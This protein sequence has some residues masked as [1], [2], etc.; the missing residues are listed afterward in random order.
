MHTSLQIIQIIT[1]EIHENIDCAVFHI[2]KESAKKNLGSCPL[3][4]TDKGIYYGTRLILHPGFMEKM[5]KSFCVIL[6]TNKPTNHIIIGRVSGKFHCAHKHS[7]SDWA[8]QKELYT[9]CVKLD[10]LTNYDKNHLKKTANL[11]LIFN[12]SNKGKCSAYQAVF[13]LY[14][15]LAE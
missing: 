15:N 4:R 6:L 12:P 10:L 2:I 14:A 1:W 9:F 8:N 3:S 5:S 13:S 7:G 11:G